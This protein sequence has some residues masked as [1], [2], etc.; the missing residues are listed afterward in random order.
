ML[1]R[2]LGASQEVKDMARET[3]EG[4]LM[5]WQGG[6]N[7]VI[8]L[9]GDSEWVLY[10]GTWKEGD[11]HVHPDCASMTPPS[12]ELSVPVR[13]FGDLWCTNKP[14][15]DRLGWATEEEQECSGVVQE[16]DRG[17]LMMVAREDT[18]EMFVFY[19][20]NET[21]YGGKWRQVEQETPIP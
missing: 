20:E 15:R 7:Q 9:Y 13:G 19:C 11:P 1:G 17:Q 16:F 4:G 21:C 14:V 12:A 10:D 2:A 5:L 6:T 8:V 3:F 18:E